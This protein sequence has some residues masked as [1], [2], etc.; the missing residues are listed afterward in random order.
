MIIFLN[1][2]N[3]KKYLKF[4]FLGIKGGEKSVRKLPHSKN[5]LSLTLHIQFTF[6]SSSFLCHASIKENERKKLFENHR[7]AK[8][9]AREY[10]RNKCQMSF[11]KKLFALEIRIWCL[12][13]WKSKSFSALSTSI[14]CKFIHYVLLWSIFN[15]KTIEHHTRVGW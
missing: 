8:W 11:S 5:L 10:V 2:Y 7:K 6:H 15:K 4:N 1:V 13:K 14:R 9:Y 12:L 3:H